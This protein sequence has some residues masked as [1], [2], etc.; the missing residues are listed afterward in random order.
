MNEVKTLIDIDIHDWRTL[1]SAL[2]VPI[3]SP[4]F[5]RQGKCVFGKSSFFHPQTDTDIRHIFS[6][7]FTFY[8]KIYFTVQ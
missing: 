1:P 3:S 6:S 4:H 5:L 7:I 8:Y 2:A